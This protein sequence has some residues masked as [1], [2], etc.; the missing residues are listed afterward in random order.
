MRTI[1]NLL[2]HICLILCGTFITFF[3]VDKFNPEMAFINNDASKLM[4][5]VLCLVSIAVSLMLVL[6]RRRED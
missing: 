2:P 3:I 1:K 5:L 4:L 6:R